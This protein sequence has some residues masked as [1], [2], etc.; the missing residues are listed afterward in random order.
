MPMNFK[1]NIS[2]FERD[3]TRF[4]MVMLLQAL[5]RNDRRN[6]NVLAKSV[7]RSIYDHLF[8]SYS[9]RTQENGAAMSALLIVQGE[10]RASGGCLMKMKSFGVLV[11]LLLSSCLARS[12]PITGVTQTWTYDPVVKTWHVHIVNVSHKDITAVVI[13]MKAVHPDGTTTLTGE[14]Y[15][16]FLPQMVSVAEYGG[17]TGTGAFAPGETFDEAVPGPES[18]AEFRKEVSAIAYADGTA[19][20]TE[21]D[22]LQALQDDRKGLLLATQKVNE[23]I[24]KTLADLTIKDHQAAVQA[25]LIRLTIVYRNQT[26]DTVALAEGAALGMINEGELPQYK[27]DVALA[28]YLERSKQRV[29]LMAPHTILKAVQP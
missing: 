17:G 18:E 14:T 24:A 28:K 20:A 22:A 26:S 10:L 12:A 11:L 1:P 8:F 13:V 5:E 7:L 2:I 29:A 4:S 25:E 21:P 15:R 3:H 27:D 23:V 16:D 9:T 19:E 6:L